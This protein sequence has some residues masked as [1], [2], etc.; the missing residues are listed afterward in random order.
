MKRVV[1]I[2]GHPDDHMTA[3]GFL[4]LLKRRGYE[5]FEIVLT[6]GSGGYVSADE[7]NTIVSTRM[8]EFSRA[9]DLLGMKK[10]SCLGYDEHVL[11][12]NKENV[13]AVTKILREVRPDI[14]ILPNRD[15]YH[16]THL[17]TN[18][19]ATKAIR[20]A[21][22]MRKLELGEPIAPSVILEWEYSV[23]HQP[24]VVVDISDYWELK[25]ALME[26]YGSQI[27]EAE[28]RKTEGLS[29]YRGASIGVRHGEGFR[30][31]RFLPL[32]LDKIME[33]IET[34][35]CSDK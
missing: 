9:S 7:K 6:G 4:S 17:E 12:M 28:F 32:R 21:M 2:S 19:I 31:N 26:C 10:T 25:K 5:L 16:E 3:A 20:T 18:K 22:K 1:F 14:I 15:D 29:V 34:G 27:N 24:D 13:E 11:A 33:L 35:H 23:P 8:K 30:I